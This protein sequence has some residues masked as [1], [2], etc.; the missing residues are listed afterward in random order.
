MEP[1]YIRT[2]EIVSISD[3]MLIGTLMPSLFTDR[4]REL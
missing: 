3:L 2:L 4:V 1:L